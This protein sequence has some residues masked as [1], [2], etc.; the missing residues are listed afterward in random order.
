MA[1]LRGFDRDF[2]SF[3]VPDLS[4]HD[5][6][7]ILAQKGAHCGCEGQPNLWVDID[8]IDTRQVYFRGILS[9][10]DIGILSIE[11][12]ESGVE[13]YGLAAT[14]RSGYQ[15]H[16]LRFA[17]V[18]GIE[19]LLERLITKG[20]DAQCRLRRIENTHHDLLAEQSRAG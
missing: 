13:G 19:F 1:G 8:L 16:S 20:V 5:H 4:D 14:G 7:G 9:S 15:N 2:G 10:R 6:I 12:V 11:D 17:E 18:L 3:K